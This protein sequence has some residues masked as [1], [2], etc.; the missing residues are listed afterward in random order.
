MISTNDFRTGMT[1]ELDGTVYSIEDFQ[2]SKSGRGGAFVRTKLKN[3]EENYVVEKT[4]RAGE[5]VKNAHIDERDVKFLYWDGQD[6][7]FM[8]NESYDQITLSKEQLGDKVNYLKENMDLK[9]AMYEGRAIEVK[10]PTFVELEVKEAPPSVKGNTVS[11]GS[12][13]VT[14]ETGLEV[15]VPL[16]ISEGEVIKV[17]TRNNEYV[18]RV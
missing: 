18:E 10:L 5:K 1:I 7:V 13:S 16:F 9:I 11:G 8:D 6:Y 17:D 4:F 3:M 14:L 15:K 12:K 2:H